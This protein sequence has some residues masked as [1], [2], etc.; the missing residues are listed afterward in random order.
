MFIQNTNVLIIALTTKINFLT[1]TNPKMK[2]VKTVLVAAFVGLG[3]TAAN[4]QSNSPDIPNVDDQSKARIA[5]FDEDKQDAYNNPA[6][7]LTD[8]AQIAKYQAM[9]DKLNAAIAAEGMYQLPGFT[10]T[11]DL[12]QD[13]LNYGQM[14]DDLKIKQPA[15]Y[16]AITEVQ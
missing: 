13:E 7:M 12:V 6:L 3:F 10:L 1:K 15:L 11:G 4:A 16:K 5:A 9:E 14:L 2:V 8:P